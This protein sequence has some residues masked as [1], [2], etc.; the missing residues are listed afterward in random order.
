MAPAP[1]AAVG[2]DALELGGGVV[3][4][5]ERAAGDGLT[6]EQSDQ[7]AA[8]RRRELVGRISAQPFRHRFL[9]AAVPAGVLDRQLGQQR[10]GQRIILADR[11]EAEFVDCVTRTSLNCLTP[12]ACLHSGAGD[13]LT[14]I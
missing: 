5:A 8:A 9:G 10:L 7:Q 2:P 6:V 4:A 11:H 14:L 12:V 13:S 1:V 3:E